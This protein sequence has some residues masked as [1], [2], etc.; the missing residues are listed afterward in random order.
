MPIHRLQ[1]LS[2]HMNVKNN[3][4]YLHI[5]DDDI[6]KDIEEIMFSENIES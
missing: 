1:I 4:H 5:S 3:T 2:G 6:A